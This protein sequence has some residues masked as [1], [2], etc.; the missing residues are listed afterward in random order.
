MVSKNKVKQKFDGCLTVRQI[1]NKQ[2]FVVEFTTYKL[3]ISY[4]TVV[5]FCQV[6][7]LTWKIVD[8]RYSATTNRHLNL[9]KAANPFE[10]VKLDEFK[11]QLEQLLNAN[12]CAK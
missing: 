2:L 3:L 4:Y 7:A 11:T 1:F 12:S 10:I 8:Y 6:N 9:W 5:G